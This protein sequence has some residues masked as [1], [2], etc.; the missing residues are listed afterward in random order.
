MNIVAA[1]MPDLQAIVQID[2]EMIGNTSRR[3][4]IENAIKQ[5]HCILV[6]ENN[7]AAG[8][9]IYDTNFFECTFISLV[10][11]SPGKRRKGYASQLL[12]ELVRTSPTEKV[13]SSANRSNLSMQKVFEAN[14]FVES[15]IVENLDEGDPEIIYFKAK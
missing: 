8:F 1:Q 13:F 9:A 10:I 5:E 14:G 7:E 4:M 15:G 2:S 6:K 12:N 3:N 11:V